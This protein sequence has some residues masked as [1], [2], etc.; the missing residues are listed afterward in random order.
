VS[1]DA[2][3]AAYRCAATRSRQLLGSE[4]L[5][6]TGQLCGVY[7]ALRTY[8]S[9]PCDLLRTTWKCLCA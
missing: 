8:T 6:A 3:S 2:A 1:A 4:C 7:D 5:A 9:K